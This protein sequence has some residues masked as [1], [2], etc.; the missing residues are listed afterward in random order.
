MYRYGIKRFF[1]MVTSLLALPFLLL[2]I[3]PIAIL[4]KLED[5]GPLFYNAPRLGKDMEE[6]KMYKFRSMKVNAPDIRNEDGSTFNSEDDPRVTSIGRFLRKTSIDELPQLL[7]VLKG[8]M[9]FVGP[10][11]SPLGNKD[12]YPKEYFRKFEV[13]PGITGYN[14]AVLRNKSTMEQRVKNDIFYVENMSLV[15]DIKI[16]YMTFV[17]VIRSKN[18]NRFE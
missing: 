16:L 8:D 9:S 1:D 2:I 18:I 15:L 17:S 11:P 12:L 13:K 7:N 14:Q 6:F 10:R 4:I 5:R 3:I